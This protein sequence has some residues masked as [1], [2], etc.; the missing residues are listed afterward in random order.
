MSTHVALIR[1]INVGKAK[2]VAMAELRAEIEALGY[3]GVKTLLNSGNVVFTVPKGAKGDPRER[4]ETVLAKRLGVPARVTVLTTAELERALGDGPFARGAKDPSKALVTFFT[5]PA[6]AKLLAPLAQRAFGRETL[7]VGKA[8]A[9]LDC[10]DGVLGGKLWSAV[11]KALGDRGTARNLAT[12]T[13]LA[14][15]ARD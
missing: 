6:D 13:K 5:S 2:R 4:I 15:L 1:G 12:L 7:V 9:W 8:C 11:D 10:P 14:L 3:A